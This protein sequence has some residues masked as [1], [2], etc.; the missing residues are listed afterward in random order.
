MKS[1]HKYTLQPKG[2]QLIELPKGAKVLSCAVQ[3]ENVVIWAL[4]DLEETGAENIEVTAFPTG[5]IIDPDRDMGVFLGTVL[6]NETRIV[7][8]IYYKQY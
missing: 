3:Q 4:V 7:L 8:H 1:I 5:Q 2:I 6:L